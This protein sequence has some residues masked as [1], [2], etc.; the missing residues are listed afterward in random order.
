MFRTQI[1]LNRILITVTN[2]IKEYLVAT[3]TNLT[4]YFKFAMGY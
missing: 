2:S 4:I 3:I 1:L